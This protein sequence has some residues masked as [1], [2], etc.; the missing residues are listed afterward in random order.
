MAEL[1]NMGNGRWDVITP[2]RTFVIHESDEHT[3]DMLADFKSDPDKLNEFES[4][5]QQHGID[6]FKVYN[7][8]PIESGI[9]ARLKRFIGI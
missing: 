4:I 5:L 2:D 3:A 7:E 9:I 8:I 6:A 1:K